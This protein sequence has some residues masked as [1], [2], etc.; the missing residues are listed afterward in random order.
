M[1][2]P[3]NLIQRPIPSTGEMLPV[4]GVGTWNTFDV[5]ESSSERN[6]LAGVLKTLVEKGGK[7]IDSS[8]MYGSSERVV[9][10]LSELAGLNQKLFIATKVWTCGADKGVTQ[11][12]NS[13]SLLK[14]STIDLMQVH[15]VVD[16]QTHLKTLAS[17]KESG[18]TRYIGLTHYVDSAHDTL[19]R[20]IK[21]NSVDFIQINYNL[22]DRH[23]EEELLPFA[24][25]KRIA[26]IINRPFEE[27]ALFRRVKEKKLPEWAADF[28]CTSWGQF[29]LKYI[30]S[31]P[32]V[33][34]VIPGTA[35]PNHLLDNLAGGMG[36]LP[37]NRQRTEMI[38]FI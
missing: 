16:W 20:I 31:H 17:W 6:P 36:R 37:D 22:L 3:G 13:L 12:S 8:P 11:M 19:V 29:F 38:K 28:D 27:G 7:L 21:E 10:E 24:Q 23:A 30:V 33:T 25:D 9:G 34:C 5:G 32:A 15:N 2:T 1:S 14:R 18:K 26:V 35:K 4:I